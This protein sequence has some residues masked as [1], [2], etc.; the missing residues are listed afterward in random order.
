M[1]RR[2]WR[3]VS[4]LGILGSLA[5]WGAAGAQPEPYARGS[6]TLSGVQDSNLFSATGDSRQGDSIS[7]LTPEIEGGFRSA[8]LSV[9]GRY[10]LDAERFAD[11][12]ELDTNRARQIATLDFQTRPAHPLSL[13]LHGDYVSTLTPGELN[14]TTGLLAARLR[15]TR[16]SVGPT[17]DW[18]LGPATNA[19]ASF[20]QTKDDVVS[21]IA[22]QTRTTA[23]GLERRLSPRSTG[24]LGYTLGRYDFGGENVTTAHT[25]SLGWE[26]S[27]GSLGGFTLRGGPR[28]SAGRVDPEVSLVMRRDAK[29]LHVSLTCGRSLGTV[30]G[31]AGTVVTDSVLPAV[32]WQPLRSLQVSAAPGVFRTRDASGGPEA[33]VYLIDLG[34]IWRIGDWLSI[35]G[36]YRRS[37]QQGALGGAGS[38]GAIDEIA[39]DTLMLSLVASQGKT[40]APAGAGPSQEV[41]P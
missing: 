22:I 16:L 2:G 3:I 19:I 38:A 23:L 11:H 8:R 7:R 30:I 17:V 13:S 6:L 36:T 41:A 39:R 20:T 26:R 15:A 25:L 14:L 9:A 24:S 40:R 34:A 31:R 32:S 29:R 37:L 33:R 10:A 4:E 12:P 1:D 28:Y 21:G 27:V 35:A 18:R 5:F